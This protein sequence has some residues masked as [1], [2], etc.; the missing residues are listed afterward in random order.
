MT[1]EERKAREREAPKL[2]SGNITS[3]NR[4]VV[5]LQQLSKE[6][7]CGKCKVPLSLRNTDKSSE[8]QSGLAFQFKVKCHI[9]GVFH[10]VH[11]GKRKWDEKTRSYLYDM[12]C[13]LSLG[14]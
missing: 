8:R 2:S 5:E 11:T 14:K 1:R 3:T 7:W 10:P 4:R 13:K 6:L 9:C 12:N